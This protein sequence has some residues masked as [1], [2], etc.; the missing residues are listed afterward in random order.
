MNPWDY[1]EKYL[2]E[3]VITNPE[4]EFI[5]WCVDNCPIPSELELQLLDIER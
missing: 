1:S 4:D 5:E 3:E 2:S